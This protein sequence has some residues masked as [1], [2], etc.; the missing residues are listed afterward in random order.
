M[1]AGESRRNALILAAIGSK[2]VAGRSGKG[3][4][5]AVAFLLAAGSD[6]MQRDVNGLIPLHYAAESK[7][8]ACVRVLLAHWSAGDQ[9]EC[10]REIETNGRRG[11][12]PKP[13][14]SWLSTGGGEESKEGK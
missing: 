9:R 5:G 12:G 14:L 11:V 3:S 13:D 2:G 10:Q 7:D 6:P 1:L 8:E 4:P